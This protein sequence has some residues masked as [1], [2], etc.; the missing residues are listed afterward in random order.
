VKRKWTKDP[1]F[2]WN[3]RRGTPRREMFA[4]DKIY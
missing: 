3:T 1:A 2:R 4:I